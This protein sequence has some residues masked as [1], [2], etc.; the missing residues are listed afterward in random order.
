MPRRIGYEAREEA[1]VVK[2][3]QGWMAA[4]VIAAGGLLMAGGGRVSAKVAPQ[5]PK[6]T[7]AE[8]ESA[9][10]LGQKNAPI[11][12]EDFSDFQCPMCRQFYLGQ[13]QQL[14]S[15]YVSTGKVY[16]VHHD[17]P[18]DMHAHS[19]EAAK[20]AD[21]AAAIGK[22]QQVENV[23]YTR[24]DDWGATGKIEETLATVLTPAEMK[25]VKAL[26]DSPE[27]AAALQKDKELGIQRN[28][29]STPSIFVTPKGGQMVSLPPAGTT[30]SLLKSYLDY[31][32]KH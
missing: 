13:T 14:I 25:R 11:M 31:L 2:K 22:F 20:W 16:L 23:L 26:V 30:Y 32:L 9:K 28:V 6:I 3:S 27:V 1:K 10:T 29:N 12:L 5:Q 17:F 8:I 19:H 24:Q 4:I 15:E 21:A 18:L 7:T